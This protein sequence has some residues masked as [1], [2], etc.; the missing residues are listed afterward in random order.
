VYDKKL[1]FILYNNRSDNERYKCTK[2]TVV[3]FIQFQLAYIANHLYT[4]NI[5]FF[6]YNRER[7][8]LN[9]GYIRISTKFQNVE[10]QERNIRLM[11]PDPNLVIIKEIFT[12]STQ[13]RPKWRRYYPRFMPGDNIYFDSVSRMARDEDDGVKEYLDLYKRKVNLFFFVEPGINTEVYREACQMQIPRTGTEVDIILE[14]IEAYQVKL[15]EKQVRIAFQQAHKEL[16]D[17]RQRTIEGLETARRSGKQLG[18]PR[19]RCITE[20]E[21]KAKNIILKRDTLFGGDLCPSD[22]M[23]VI[24]ISRG[25]YYKYR[26]D[27]SKFPIA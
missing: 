4:I 27:L 23:K 5:T 2:K 16:D 12:G 8:A 20:K 19:G 18:R 7:C 25:T 26:N 17:L 13:D 3:F 24:G 15:A 14:A 1:T 10:R 9:Y 21:R 22:C 6:S 11:C